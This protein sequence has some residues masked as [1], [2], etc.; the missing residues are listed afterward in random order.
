MAI[1]AAAKARGLPFAGHVPASMTPMEVSD[2][3]QK[4]IEHL[5]FV[6]KPCHALFES[7]TGGAPRSPPS[8]CDSQSLDELLH[9]FAHNGTWLDPTIQSFRYWAPTQWNAIFSGFRGLVPSIRE[10]HVLRLLCICSP[11]GQENFF[12]ELGVKVATRTTAP[13]K[14]SPDEQAAFLKKAKEITPRYRTELLKEA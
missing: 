13:P 8:G 12:M 11:A 1:V 2:L 9:R 7:V 3:G 5:E 4:S 6:P 14:L 10:N